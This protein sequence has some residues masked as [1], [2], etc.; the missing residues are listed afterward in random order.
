M[1][2]RACQHAI[3]IECPCHDTDRSL[4][5]STYIIPDLSVWLKRIN[6]GAYTGYLGD[7]SKTTWEAENNDLVFSVHIY[8]LFQVC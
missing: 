4:R 7:A 6:P 3:Q 2:P 8:R 5:V 1:G